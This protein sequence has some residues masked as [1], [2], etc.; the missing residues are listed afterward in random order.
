MAKIAAIIQARLGSSRLPLKSLLTLRGKPVIDWVVER[1]G[2]S[3]ALAGNI[4]VALPDTRLDLALFEHLRSQNVTCIFGSEDDVLGRMA[5]A[6][7]RL[8]ADLVIRVCADNP[9]VWGEAIDQLADF[10]M[11]GDFDYAYNHVPKNNLWPDGLGAEI[12]SRKLL[13]ELDNVARS[14]TQ[15][16]HCLNYIWDNP[17]MFKIGTFNPADERLRRPDVKL[18]LDTVRDFEKLALMPLQPDMEAPEIIRTYDE[19]L[20]G[21][22]QEKK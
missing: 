18:D 5:K 7:A 22:G 4:I 12:V 3:R 17:A 15:R 16:E 6:A 20:A 1:L 10:Y 19:S 9:L 13:L 21:T 14:P 11:N 2:S 8:E